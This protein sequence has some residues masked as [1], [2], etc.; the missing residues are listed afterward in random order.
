MPSSSLKRGSGCGCCLG[1]IQTPRY[2]IEQDLA[3]GTL[4]ECLPDTPPSPISVTL[5]RRLYL[6]FACSLRDG[7][8]APY[9]EEWPTSGDRAMLAST[10]S[11]KAHTFAGGK[12]RDGR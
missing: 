1:L 12:C 8:R 11:T 5:T 9:H 7:G 2:S 4:V 3:D 6:P 10:K